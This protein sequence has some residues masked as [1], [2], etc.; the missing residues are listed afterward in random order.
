MKITSSTGVLSVAPVGTNPLDTDQWAEIGHAMADAISFAPAEPAE[1][2]DM[3]EALTKA[4]TMILEA[5]Y[6]PS[7]EALSMF[8]GV[9]VI[10]SDLLPRSVPGVIFDAGLMTIFAPK[11]ETREFTD[12]EREGEWAKRAVRHGMADVLAWLNED[13]GPEP[14]LAYTDGLFKMN[15][16]AG[17][18]GGLL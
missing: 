7:P 3:L 15:F 4:R 14:D 1:P 8:Y 6:Q 18:A 13:V 10:E 9:P 2:V 16:L 11:A 12:L 17:I 5:E